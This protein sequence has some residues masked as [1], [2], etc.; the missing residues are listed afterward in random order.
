MTFS[1]RPLDF[2]EDGRAMGQNLLLHRCAG[3]VTT[4]NTSTWEYS[5]CRCVSRN[6]S[7][8][9]ILADSPYALPSPPGR[10]RNARKRSRKRSRSSGVISSQRSP[11][12][13]D[14]VDDAIAE[15]AAKSGVTPATAVEAES[16]E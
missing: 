15:F 16:A 7:A 3:T 14:A 9:G 10:S 5:R 8:T 4:P 1:F 12:L 11:T 13:G 2:A 6:S